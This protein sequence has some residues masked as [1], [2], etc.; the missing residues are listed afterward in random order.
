MKQI[1][2]GNFMNK[3]LPAVLL[4]TRNPAALESIPAVIPNT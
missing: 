4:A 2:K 3:R 1:L